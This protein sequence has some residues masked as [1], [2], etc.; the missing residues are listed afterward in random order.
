MVYVK[1]SDRK[2]MCPY[3]GKPFKLESNIQTEQEGISFIC[4]GVLYTLKCNKCQEEFVYVRGINC[5]D[6]LNHFVEISKKMA[7][8][9]E[10][11][12]GGSVGL[13]MWM[14][15]GLNSSS[16]V[17]RMEEAAKKLMSK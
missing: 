3:C 12:F 14:G 15:L 10:N 8:M 2:Q 11:A 16:I 1:N 17:K 13:A 4:T 6:S 7:K 9:E 5:P